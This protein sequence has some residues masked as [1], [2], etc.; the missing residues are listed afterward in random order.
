MT[1][2]LIR[3]SYSLPLTFFT[4]SLRSSGRKRELARDGDTRGGGWLLLARPFFLVPTISK[5]LL[6]RLLY[7]LLPG[8]LEQGSMLT[9]KNCDVFFFQTTKAPSLWPWIPS[10]PSVITLVFCFVEFFA[11]FSAQ[12]LPMQFLNN[13][14]PCILAYL[15]NSSSKI[16]EELKEEGKT[17]LG[18]ENSVS[19]AS[20][21]PLQED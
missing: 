16:R 15:G 6:R 19:N 9:I 14:C 13:L 7:T 3:A 11:A 10:I 2:E 18:D 5:R 8:F 17:W 1:L 20:L 4:P 21:V 12:E